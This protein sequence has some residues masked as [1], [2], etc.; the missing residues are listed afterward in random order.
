MN[1]EVKNVTTDDKILLSCYEQVAVL[2][3]DHQVFLVQHKASHN[4]F[5]KK[6]LSVYNPAVFRYLKECPVKGIPQI[7]EVIEDG[8]TL[9]VIEEYI[10]GRTL[11]SLLDDGNLFSEKEAVRIILQLC[12]ILSDLHGA[13]PPIVHRDIKP[14][15]VIVTS[16]GDVRL[17]DINAAKQLHPGQSEDT[18]LIGTN[19]YAAPEQYGFGA[20]GLQTDIYA[21]GILLN[22]M[23]LGVAPRE[24]TVPGK[25]GSVIKRCIMMDPESRY[26]SAD[27]LAE[28]LQDAVSPPAAADERPVSMD[29]EPSAD[30]PGIP[31]FRSGNPAHIIIA[32]TGY[33]LIFYTGLTLQISDA[34]SPTALLLNKIVFIITALCV[35]FFTCNCKNI[36]SRLGIS[37]IRSIFTKT[38]AVAAI[39]A[40]IALL[41]V[42]IMVIIE[43]LL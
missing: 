21:L 13:A 12:G 8:D 32:V 30:R 6:T 40:A 33:L 35:V 38:L 17:I 1:Q 14:S 18:S 16:A 5:V 31:G 23:I 10:S 36:W 15:N 24:T 27:A 4:I 22:E 34:P 29:A 42:L 41:L 7:V 28:A 19:G 2:N 26:P 43:S 37:R 3:E 25:I 9:I 39:D 11:R 20:S